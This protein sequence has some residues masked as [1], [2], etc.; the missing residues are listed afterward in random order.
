M[1]V[2]RYDSWKDYPKRRDEE[3]RWLCRWCGEPLCGRRTSWCSKACMR[4]V[5]IRCG[6]GVRRAVWLRDKSVCSRCGRDTNAIRRRLRETKR[7]GGREAWLRAL[8]ELD[9]TIGEA[10]KTLWQAHH[11]K[12][13]EEGGGG[14]GVE[15]YGTLC[16]WCHK[17]ENAKQYR[18]KR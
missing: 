9:L 4:E 7:T 3:G 18:R 15:G 16:V 12:S 11:V 6:T 5:E 8:K 10:L 17:A 2:K 1:M 13:V 14:C